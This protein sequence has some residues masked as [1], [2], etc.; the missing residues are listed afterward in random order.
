[1]RGWLFLLIT[2]W[3]PFCAGAQIR[4]EVTQHAP[5]KTANQRLFFACDFNNW[6][7]GNVEYELKPDANGVY[8]LDLPDSLVY[9]KYKITQ[10][11]WGL[12][13]G[14]AKGNS[15]PDR[16]Y[17]R[18]TEANPKLLQL[19]IEGWEAHSTYRFVVTAIPD[20][21]PKDATLYITGNFNNW[22]AGDEN[23]RLR[24]QMDGTYRVTIVSDLER[25][26]YKFTRGDWNSV[27]GK[28]NGKTRPNR[29]LYRDASLKNDN[30]AVDIVSWE[31]LSGIFHSISIY[32]LLL[33]FSVFQSVLL[34]IAITSMQDYNRQANRWLVVSLAFMAIIVLIRVVSAY[35][36]VAQEYTK[37]LL[38]PDFVL[39]LYAPL[40]YFY[41]QKLLFKT[42]KFPAK[43]WG[44]FIL[45]SLQLLMY[46]P[47][48]FMEDK[49]LQIKIVNRDADLLWLFWGTGT[50]A[51]MVNVYYWV[52]SRRVIRSYRALYANQASYEQNLQYLSTVLALQAVCLF[53]WLFS[54]GLFGIGYFFKIE[55]ST[56]VQKSI[57]T[58]WLAFSTIPYFLGYFAIHQPEIF[59]L[60]TQPISFLKPNDEPSIVIQDALSP[61]VEKEPELVGNLSSYKEKVEGYM[62]KNKPY[63]NPGL[64]LNELAQKLK[65]TPHLLSKIINEGYDKN[66]F[67]FINEYR[68]EEFKQRFEDPRN[69]QYTMLAIAFEVGFNSKT[70]FN[71]A[72][73]KM[74]QQTPREFFYESRAEE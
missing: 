43:W 53:L 71:R 73:K 16:I 24:R 2:F 56:I 42:P 65:L 9:F 15:R 11:S 58:I 27:E 8:S 18:L 19:Q 59:K 3:L 32:D 70:S 64:T 62:K 25:L 61:L 29:L 63:T 67:D 7:P 69:R 26:E 46:L 40:F 60:P 35:R 47:Y 48:F 54:G 34:I 38:I 45:P 36:E 57:D 52:A 10:G 5:F 74:T 55:T 31:D 14:D 72:F 39:F 20:N 22:N 28:E 30:I 12:V 23:Y 33:L 41:I 50:V 21:T 13:E 49:R 68:I 6:Q 17:D 51:L 4:V 44:H 37:L 1:M 66:F